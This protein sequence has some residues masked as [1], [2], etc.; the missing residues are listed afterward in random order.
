MAVKIPERESMSNRSKDI[1]LDD[2]D[3]EPSLGFHSS[4]TDRGLFLG[5]L[6]REE[7]IRLLQSHGLLRAIEDAGYPNLAIEIEAGS[8][9]DNRLH[10]KSA[11]GDELLLLRLRL[12]DYTFPDGSRREFLYIDWLALQNVN[13]TRSDLFPGQKYPGLGFH[14]F[15]RLTGVLRDLLEISGAD[16]VATV[17]EYFHDAAL[18]QRQGYR[19][20]NPVKAARFAGVAS[21]PDH[22][23]KQISRAVHEEQVFDSNTGDPYLWRHG[24]MIFCKSDVLGALIFDTEYRRSFE[25]EVRSGRFR[26]LKD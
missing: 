1:S 18:F 4:L 10:I 20:V 16:G 5:R 13:S 17:P 19:F 6:P 8:L 15:K 23:L 21:L 12:H 14:V 25:R 3:L 24:E 11:D 9:L 26:I 7:V 22:T 2:L